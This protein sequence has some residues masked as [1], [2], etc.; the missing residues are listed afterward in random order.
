MLARSVIDAD[1][2]K[3]DHAH[4][5]NRD[6]GVDAIARPEPGRDVAGEHQRAPQYRC[7]TALVI[8]LRLPH[9]LD[10]VVNLGQR[11]GGLPAVNHDCPAPRVATS[12]AIADTA[13]G[14]LTMP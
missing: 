5:V 7:H 10:D 2:D 1:C 13:F 14:A 11:F 6:P 3:A 8:E 12:S 9:A 4:R